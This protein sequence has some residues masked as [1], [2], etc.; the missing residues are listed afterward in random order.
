MILQLRE[1]QSIETEEEI[2]EDLPSAIA[3]SSTNNRSFSYFM[4]TVALLEVQDENERIAV[5]AL[6]SMRSGTSGLRTLP[7]LSTPASPSSPTY[8][9]VSPLPCS[10]TSPTSTTPTQPSVS[11]TSVPRP[12]TS[13]LVSRMSQLPIVESALWAY[14]QGKASSRVVK[15]GAEMMESSM[16]SMSRPIMDRLPVD[17]LDEYAG[18]QFDRLERYRGASI[19]GPERP[20]FVSSLD[21]GRT[22]L[23]SKTFDGSAQEHEAW[24]QERDAS[25]HREGSNSRSV[26]HVA[27]NVN[28][29][30]QAT[31]PY[32]SPSSPPPPLDSRSVTPVQKMD[33]RDGPRPE[34]ER[35][36]RQSALPDAG[37]IGAAFSEDNMKK[38]KYCLEWLQYA[39]ARIDAQILILRDFTSGL[40]PLPSESLSANRRP[41]ISEEH[42]K[43]LSDVRRDI[44]GTIRQ[45]VDIVS[46]YAGTSLPEPARDKVRSFILTLPQ[47]WATKAGPAV[48]NPAPA[49]P[50]EWCPTDREKD[51]ERDRDRDRGE[52]V[53]AAGNGGGAAARRAG[54]QR[55]A[56]AQRER[57]SG[58]GG[59]PS[60]PPSRASSPSPASPRINRASVAPAT[61]GL[62]SHQTA[63]T[64]AQRILTLATESLDMMRNVTV[65]MKESLDKAEAW[66][67]RIRRVGVQRE[68]PVGE[69]AGLPPIDDDRPHS[70]APDQPRLPPL[71][72]LTSTAPPMRHRYPQSNHDRRLERPTHDNADADGEDEEDTA[73][74]PV[75]PSDYGTSSSTRWDRSNS[76]TNLTSVSSSSLPRSS[77]SHSSYPHHSSDPKGYSR[78]YS[79]ESYTWSKS[80][81]SRR[82]SP[83][84]LLHPPQLPTHLPPMLPNFDGMP[85][86]RMD[87]NQIIEQPH[88]GTRG[89]VKR[90]EDID[91][92]RDWEQERSQLPRYDQS[93]PHDSRNW[94]TERERKERER[95]ARLERDLMSREQF[96]NDY[97][98]TR[99]DDYGRGTADEE[100]DGDESEEEGRRMD[101]EY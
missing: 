65:V 3:P 34:A 26:G 84:P 50:A 72:L 99:R 52:T 44:I 97:Q 82:H 32:I 31:T 46:K 25:M 90:E 5:K 14:E 89:I 36:R 98:S 79:P 87:V 27:P 12:P 85:T 39:T 68:P 58:T 74:S 55:R 80:S 62:P 38:I 24:T 30:I 18:R 57:G 13:G 95:Q 66:V 86:R 40:Q 88:A 17:Q 16:K 64:A 37:G 29:W 96:V 7:P 48:T 53:V 22:R 76:S 6:G 9:T 35:T 93:Q 77:R 61:S 8:Q 4:T 1:G 19:S 69:S 23:T 94:E 56:A 51:R 43:R 2:D 59:G 60:T 100:D 78:Q 45:V 20:E 75:Y 67:D 101:I 42:M 70:S 54:A 81:S 47:R 10:P 83:P 91:E 15:Y 33:H 41:P 28:R 73:H 21:R 49:V 11:S 92:R 71:S 63:A